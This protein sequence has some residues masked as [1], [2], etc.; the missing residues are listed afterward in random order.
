MNVSRK[1]HRGEMMAKKKLI[2]NENLKAKLYELRERLADIPLDESE[3]E[4]SVGGHCGEQCMV[5]C[6]WWCEPTCAGGCRGVGDYGCA[7]KAVCPA[8]PFL[9]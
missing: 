1:K 4:K 6:S 2:V 9:Q 7:Y 5:T 8:A 3:M